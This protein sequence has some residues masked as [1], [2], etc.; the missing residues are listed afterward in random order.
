MNRSPNDDDE[1]LS[2]LF[3]SQPLGAQPLELPPDDFEPDITAVEQ[4]RGRDGSILSGGRRR[5]RVNGFDISGVGHERSLERVRHQEEVSDDAWLFSDVVRGSEEDFDSGE[6]DRNGGGGDGSATSGSNVS[7]V[8]SG[9]LGS[10]SGED[11]GK[12]GGGG[13][14]S[15]DEDEARASGTKLAA[16]IGKMECTTAWSSDSDAR[17]RRAFVKFK[18]SR[19][20]RK[21]LPKGGR[22]VLR[23]KSAT[24]KVP[25]TPYEYHR[26]RHE[27]MRRRERV[28]EASR[29]LYSA[30]QS[31]RQDI[32]VVN[33]NRMGSVFLRDLYPWERNPKRPF[34][35]LGY[36]NYKIYRRC[37]DQ[38]DRSEFLSACLRL[39]RLVSGERIWRLIGTPYR[40]AHW[41]ARMLHMFR[42]LSQDLI[43]RGD[44]P[45]DSSLAPL[46][47]AY[48]ADAL[49]KVIDYGGTANGILGK[50][51][52]TAHVFQALSPHERGANAYPPALPLSDST[53][54]VVEMR[55]REH[56][57]LVDYGA[58]CCGPIQSAL[59][60]Y[61]LE[62]VKQYAGQ[63]LLDKRVDSLV[64][65]R[66]AYRPVT[67]VP[68]PENQYKA[69]V[70]R[71][72]RT[73]RHGLF[74]AFQAQNCVMYA[75]PASIS[76]GPSRFTESLV[77]VEK[78]LRFHCRVPG[79]DDH[80][81]LKSSL[82]RHTK[83]WHL[84]DLENVPER[85]APGTPRDAHKPPKGKPGPRGPRILPL[86][87][88]EEKVRTQSYAE[89]DVLM[90]G[91]DCGSDSLKSMSESDEE[92]GVSDGS[93]LEPSF[94]VRRLVEDMMSGV[95]DK[96]S[97]GIADLFEYYSQ[98]GI[99]FE[100]GDVY[101]LNSRQYKWP[102][103][104]MI[105]PELGAHRLTHGVAELWKAACGRL[106]AM[107]MSRCALIQ[108][109]ALLDWL[110][111][112]AGGAGEEIQKGKIHEYVRPVVAIAPIPLLYLADTAAQFVTCT[113]CIAARL[114]QPVCT[115][116]GDGKNARHIT[117]I[118]VRKALQWVCSDTRYVPASSLD[119]FGAEAWRSDGSLRTK[120]QW[121]RIEARPLTDHAE[122]ILCERKPLSTIR[123]PVNVITELGEVLLYS[124]A[125][126]SD[127]EGYFD[128]EGE[129]V[130]D[131]D[132][133]FDSAQYD[134]TSSSVYTS[135]SINSYDKD[136]SGVEDEGSKAADLVMALDSDCSPD[137][138]RRGVK[139]DLHFETN[140]DELNTRVVDE[141]CSVQND[142]RGLIE[143]LR[144]T[145]DLKW[146]RAGGVVC[147][148]RL[149]SVCL[150][151]LGQNPDHWD[152][153]AASTDSY[154]AD[155]NFTSFGGSE[156]PGS[157]MLTKP[158]LDM[159]YTLA[160]SIV[161][162][163]A[164]ILAECAAH[165][166][167]RPWIDRADL[168]LVSA[169]RKETCVHAEL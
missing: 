66:L 140:H 45:F 93:Y 20:G 113:V 84:M 127:R 132:A 83:V 111:H 21:G 162:R 150:H 15:R 14:S 164:E 158:A 44:F 95:T 143:F 86:L 96:R 144:A 94:T 126:S 39:G 130:F 33:S 168:M 52:N 103:E 19:V 82:A 167:G 26:V 48:R 90:C 142:G 116:S 13:S 1:A 12:D 46:V 51:A 123:Y 148:H 131:E 49:D 98:N 99:S 151:V 23:K 55:Q 77:E 109:D 149:A 75:E 34:L 134:S 169:V 106:G 88:T 18:Y 58:I 72:R 128:E 70:E 91:S 102:T 112:V 117:D 38:L 7:S 80:F 101:D 63:E 120:K 166:D 41:C 11:S 67:G 68:F 87:S 6:W 156:V 115:A 135:S 89:S 37:M 108:N 107:N 138:G 125:L 65:E 145:A 85:V 69:R 47:E 153:S 42:G 147:Y 30:H 78:A 121:P 161:R 124:G 10:I 74:H 27:I 5:R 110:V 2:T 36:R 104:P 118:D 50:C 136:G 79:C 129:S 9:A 3:D 29:N 53:P 159:L 154:G 24:R 25:C 16:E 56:L 73:G 119:I 137:T 22:S 163:E 165:D 155:C 97:L 8:L 17:P 71:A 76:D 122:V 160:D 57:P 4:R 62:K 35:D 105:A 133:D 100:F 61:H 43:T 81:A 114:A 54:H 139:Q 64:L 59:R 152:L 40:T 32:L 157:T 141:S 146:A 28:D 31:L 92:S 60:P